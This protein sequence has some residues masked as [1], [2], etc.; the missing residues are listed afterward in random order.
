[1]YCKYC[2]TQISND[3]KFCHNCGSNVE[4]QGDVALQ[5]VVE[6]PVVAEPIEPVKPKVSIS[7]SIKSLV[8]GAIGMEFAIMAMI[9]II[10][11]I[12]VFSISV[13]TEDNGAIIAL[14]IVFLPISIIGLCFANAAKSNSDEYCALSGSPNGFSKTGRILGITARVLS[15]ISIAIYAL[16][17]TIAMFQ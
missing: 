9:F 3:S 10:E 14:V 17:G 13:G 16:F 15:I 1:M 4:P 8:F 2:G 12:A 6:Q 11:F 5:P 7:K